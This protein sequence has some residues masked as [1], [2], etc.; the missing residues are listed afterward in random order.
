MSSLSDWGGMMKSEMEENGRVRH[1]KGIFGKDV[2]VDIS[3]CY[4]SH[5]CFVFATVLE[6]QGDELHVAA[7]EN[8]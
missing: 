8:L 3:V 6:T 7:L 1:W 2:V 4:N 5:A